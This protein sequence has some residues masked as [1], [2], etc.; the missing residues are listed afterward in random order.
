MCER[1]WVN[2]Y[3][4][5]RISCDKRSPTG[6]IMAENALT[7]SADV[8]LIIASGKIRKKRK[9]NKRWGVK[10]GF[11]FFAFFLHI[12]FVD[13]GWEWSGVEWSGW[14]HNSPD[15]KK[16]RTLR[17]SC[18]PNQLRTTSKYSVRTI[19]IHEGLWGRKG[20][21]RVYNIIINKHFVFQMK[22]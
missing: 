3:E 18:S 20:G 21:S 13:F 14:K 17:L 9:E 11:S 4:K 16:L 7:V 22:Q 10:C 8:I 6:R 1:L 2:E 5:I 19:C 15:D 12:H